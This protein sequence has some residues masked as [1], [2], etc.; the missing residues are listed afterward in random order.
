MITAQ[1]ERQREILRAIASTI[2]DVEQIAFGS[3]IDME[4]RQQLLG[5]KL[6]QIRQAANIGINDQEIP[7][8]ILERYRSDLMGRLAGMGELLDDI[9]EAGELD[10]LRLQVLGFAARNFSDGVGKYLQLKNGAN[11]EVHHD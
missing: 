5:E 4:S 1:L 7:E 2:S 9:L 3:T 8:G 10:D 11:S 6:C